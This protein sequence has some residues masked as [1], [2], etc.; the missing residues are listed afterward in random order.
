MKKWKPNLISLGGLL[1]GNR[2]LQ[3]S[4]DFDFDK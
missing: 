4:T 1:G 2:S 3:V